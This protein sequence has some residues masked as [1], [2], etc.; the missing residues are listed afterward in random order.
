MHFKSLHLGTNHV[1]QIITRLISGEQESMTPHL[2]PGQGSCSWPL[3]DP[4]LQTAPGGNNTFRRPKRPHIDWL[5]LSFVGSGPI[6]FSLSLLPPL[7]S[8]LPS[9]P[10]THNL[11]FI[12][13]RWNTDPA[14]SVITAPSD[15]SSHM[16]GFLHL[17]QSGGL[18]YCNRFNIPQMS[19]LIYIH[20]T[21]D[22]MIYSTSL[23]DFP[24]RRA[25]LAL[26]GKGHNLCNKNIITHLTRLIIHAT[27]VFLCFP[28][29]NY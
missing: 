20:A 1:R 6:L 29:K 11:T 25:W 4:W 3:A 17:T 9:L 18:L 15:S 16:H 21:L 12:T 19:Q 23:I 5:P 26:R 10:G 14:P 24:S 13:S 22:G 27:C 8:S 28:A 7:P 2:S